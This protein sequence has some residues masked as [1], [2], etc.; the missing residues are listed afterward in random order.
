MGSIVTEESN[1]KKFA[2]FTS[3]FWCIGK[4]ER[5]Q[6]GLQGSPLRGAGSVALPIKFRYR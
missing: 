4:K 2:A 6:S 5:S 3:L 1:G